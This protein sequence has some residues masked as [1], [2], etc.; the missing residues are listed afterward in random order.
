MLRSPALLTLVASLLG[1]PLASASPLA[2]VSPVAPMSPGADVA[3]EAT[4]VS[5]T[6][7]RASVP[8]FSLK[9]LKG[10]RVRLEDLKGKVVVISFWATWCVPCKQ[11]LD[12][13]QKIYSAQQ[14]DDLVVLAISTDGPETA[15]QI[16]GTVNKH[17]WDFTVLHDGGGEATSLLNP[18][19]VTPYS[20]FIDRN[21]KL[22]YDHEGYSRGDAP[23]MI[24]R[25]KTLLAEK[26][27]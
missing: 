19:G 24:E 10:K 20:M 15:A 21:G 18:R 9:D 27:G 25:I 5:P 14:G 8:K 23:Q 2:S 1:T 4:E 22:A 11:E 6:A 7:G 16:R 13:L 26:A 3:G 17:K 12:E